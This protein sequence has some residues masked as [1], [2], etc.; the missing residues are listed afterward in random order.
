[1]ST[2]A[3]GRATDRF[4]FY[5]VQYARF[6]SEIATSIRREVYGEDLD[7]KVGGLSTSKPLSPI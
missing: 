5:G 4:E 7:N 2:L 6:E 3:E 1:M